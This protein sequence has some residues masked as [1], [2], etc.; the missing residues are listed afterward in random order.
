[1]AQTT[2]TIKRSQGSAA[3]ASST[4][5]FGELAYCDGTIDLYI[6]QDNNAS[7]LLVSEA[8]QV[9][10]AGDQ[11]ITG[12]KT[13][14]VSK[15]F[16]PA[17]GAAGKLLSAK[18]DSGDLEY[19]PAATVTVSSVVSNATGDAEPTAW[20]GFNAQSI[21]V[22]SGE[23]LIY[24]W[25]S[26]DGTAYIYVGSPGSP[27]VAQSS[28]DLTSLGS[29]TAFADQ[30]ATD[31]GASNNEAVA[32]STLKGNRE[33]TLGDVQ[34][35]ATSG[36][37]KIAVTAINDL[38]TQ[39]NL[40]ANNPQFV[41]ELAGDAPIPDG[42]YENGQ[43]FII[44]TST[45]TR[46]VYPAGAPSGTGGDYPDPMTISSGDWLICQ[47]GG[48]ITGGNPVAGTTFFKLG[49]SFQNQTA[50]NTTF[51]PAGSIV[52]TDVQAACVELDVD[53]V[54]NSGLIGTNTT[55]IAANTQSIS[56]IVGQDATVG[57]TVAYINGGTFP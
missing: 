19:V 26:V 52:A 16:V 32:P 29:A 49:Y 24:T 21:S 23:I 11:T 36:G 4:L 40:I 38:Q 51:A 44:S 50:A 9:E 47:T 30:P 22:S 7:G 33:S 27:A 10:L 6:G 31:L 46:S 48:G 3:P 12:N 5:E 2:L 20:E 56:G 42:T 18:T 15:L 13:I 17:T 35:L 43:Y 8:R 57:S 25:K 28:A 39:V 37:S 41:S 1:M 14:D 53:I 55:D 54:A 34:T 45:T